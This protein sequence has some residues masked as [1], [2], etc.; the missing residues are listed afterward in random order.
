MLAREPPAAAPAVS[1]SA[2]SRRRASRKLRSHSLPKVLDLP[3]RPALITR[4]CN[5]NRTTNEPAWP[6]WPMPPGETCITALDALKRPRVMA[7][8]QPSHGGQSTG[9]GLNS[10]NL[11]VLLVIC[12]A[13]FAGYTFRER[14][15]DD[16]LALG[17][18]LS[19]GV[20]SL[21]EKGREAGYGAQIDAA[22]RSIQ[23]VIDSIR[24]SLSPHTAARPVYMPT[25]ADDDDD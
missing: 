11:T 1:G 20:A 18:L 2:Y 22:E 7:T 15:R 5:L 16:A 21:L 19:A 24:S 17:A 25:A 8:Y 10:W 9:G 13:L 3:K 6:A 23:P 12:G 4:V 14:L